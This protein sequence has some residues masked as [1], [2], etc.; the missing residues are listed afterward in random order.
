MFKN[1]SSYSQ[2]CVCVECPP[3]DVFHK[4]HFHLSLQE[5]RVNN[6]INDGF[7]LAASI[8]LADSLSRLTEILEQNRG[9]INVVSKTG[10]FPV[11]PE[12]TE[13]M[14]GLLYAQGK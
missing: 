6:K 12:S 14:K 8:V 5:K 3:I 4:R 7:H 2:E 10:A 9:I 11:K 13:K 1:N